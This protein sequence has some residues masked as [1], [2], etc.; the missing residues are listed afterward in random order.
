MGTCS[1]SLLALEGSATD[2]AVA[3]A[4]RA[5]AEE[6]DNDVGKVNLTGLSVFRLGQD[7]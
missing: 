5:G 7:K 3:S 1:S 6:D 4:E 2:G